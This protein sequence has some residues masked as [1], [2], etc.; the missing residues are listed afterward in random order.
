MN[1]KKKFYCLD[2]GWVIPL[3][4][5]EKSQNNEP[6]VCEK[7]G[8]QMN[9][10]YHSAIKKSNEI[11]SENEFEELIQKSILF[12]KNNIVKPLKEKIYKYRR[13]REEKMN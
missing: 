4:L 6:I 7:C 8:F 3:D 2:C 9:N 13:Q 12:A 11:K 1:E 5:I 10:L